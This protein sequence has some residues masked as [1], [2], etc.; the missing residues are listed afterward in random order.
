MPSSEGGWGGTGRLG[1]SVCSLWLF[2]THGD[3]QRPCRRPLG[4]RSAGLGCRQ[5]GEPPGA[6]A[7]GERRMIVLA[8]HAGEWQW[9]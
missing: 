1:R 8:G 7:Y 4:S 3:R 5:I 6:C 2:L 9:L